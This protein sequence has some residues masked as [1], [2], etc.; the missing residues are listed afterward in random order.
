MSFL[1]REAL[2]K[3]R[4]RRTKIVSIR[5]DHPDA[6]LAGMQVTVRSM[7]ARERADWEMQFT[8]PKTNKPLL[9]RQREIRERLVIATVIDE[10]G[11]PLLSIDDLEALRE[12][13]SALLDMIVRASQDLND[14]T[15]DDLAELEKNSP[16]T[17]P[18]SKPSK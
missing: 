11:E 17:Q 5:D 2:L 3:K 18:A 13:D 10:R 1:S 4:A 15:D 9:D 16:K 6:D 8:N 14:I 7:N 12:V